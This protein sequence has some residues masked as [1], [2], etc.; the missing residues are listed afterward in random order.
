MQRFALASGSRIVPGEKL[1]LTLAQRDQLIAV[2]STYAE[3]LYSL[4]RRDNLF[5]ISCMAIADG[6]K[7]PDTLQNYLRQH[8]LI[9]NKYAPSR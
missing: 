7:D 4:L 3:S 2:L 6:V 1:H 9:T 8:S 5:L